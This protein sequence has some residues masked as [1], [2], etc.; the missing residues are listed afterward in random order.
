MLGLGTGA[1]L[2]RLLG[3][4]LLA[5]ALAIPV[6]ILACQAVGLKPSVKVA[7]LSTLFPI[8]LAAETHG[9]SATMETVLSRAENVLL[10]CL[11]TLA[12]DGLVWPERASARF[13]ARIRRD[14]A[15]VGSLAGDLLDSY[16]DKAER[17][18]LDPRLGE[19]QTARLAYGDMLK[20]TGLEPEDPDAPRQL[21]AAWT[22]TLHVLV[23]HCA[24]LRDIQRR[25]GEDGAQAL[26]RQEFGAVAGALREAA[27]AFGQA[28]FAGALARLREAGLRLETAYDGVRGEKGTQAFQSREIFRL[29]G[30]LYHC[31]ALVRGLGELAEAPA[32][33][34]R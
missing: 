17:D 33:Q 23:D 10:G 18:E 29:L 19:L 1:L 32:G 31:G 14:V 12:I 5:A 2:V 24:A 16:L 9:F 25:A 7:A 28:S 21:L 30:V 26:L 3:H 8:M 4:T 34:E 27:E 11:V 13:Q 22:A 20:E 15:R 6:A